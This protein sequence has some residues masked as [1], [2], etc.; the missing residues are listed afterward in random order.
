M[1]LFNF[2]QSI[3]FLKPLP[4]SFYIAQSQQLWRPALRPRRL[5]AAVASRI[6][7]P[8]G[9]T[10]PLPS[11]QVRIPLTGPLLP[12]P[13]TCAHTILL[14][15]KVSSGGVKNTQRRKNYPAVE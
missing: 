7:P 8:A 2:I 15:E 6:R 9:L 14:G 1:Y 11:A 5:L 3:Y 12:P 10:F 13:P 4:Q